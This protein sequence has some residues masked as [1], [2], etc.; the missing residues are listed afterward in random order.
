MYKTY[1]FRIYLDTNQKI[2]LV[3]LW[4]K[5]FYQVDEYYPS[6]QI[7]SVCDYQNKVYK[8]L[9]KRTYKCNNCG[10]TIDRDLNASIYKKLLIS[11]QNKISLSLRNRY[12]SDYRNLSLWSDWLQSLRSRNSSLWGDESKFICFCS[13]KDEVIF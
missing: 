9:S 7:C 8:D 13:D 5:Y 1:K 6:S 12:G 3:K 11:R 2:W 10:V 4:I